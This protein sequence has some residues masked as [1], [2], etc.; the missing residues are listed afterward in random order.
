MRALSEPS[1]ASRKAAATLSWLDELAPPAGGRIRVLG[2]RDMDNETAHAAYMLGRQ[3]GYDAGL[4]AGQLQGFEEGAKA[5]TG[6]ISA[7]ARG[8]ATRLHETLTEFQAQMAGLE[9]Q[10]ASDLVSLAIDIARQVLRQELSYSHD[11]LIPVANEALRALGEGASQIELRIHPD[12]AALLR[13]HLDTLPG[14]ARCQIVEDHAMRP[15]GLRLDAD[16]GVVDA[17]FEAR[18]QAVMLN[19]GRDEEPLP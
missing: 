7:E 2:T 1:E 8:V 12:D 14:G 18:W 10:L 6:Q 16:S 11:S 15:G 13:E 9:S 4:K 17:S 3:R 19:L 5:R